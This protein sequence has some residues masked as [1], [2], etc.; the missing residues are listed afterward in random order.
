M[1]QGT[2]QTVTFAVMSELMHRNA[3]DIALSG[4][5]DVSLE[6]ILEF[7][8]KYVTDPRFAT[9]V[10]DVMNI[11]IGWY[12]YSYVLTICHLI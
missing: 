9:L 10:F 11:L 6:P 8:F 12:Y 4:R 7:L 2:P 5:N 3:L 1:K